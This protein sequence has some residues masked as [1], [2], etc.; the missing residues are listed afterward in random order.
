MAARTRGTWNK[1]TWAVGIAAAAVLALTGYAM[2]SGDE[3]PDDEQG[4]GGSNPS[5]ASSASPSATYQAPEDWTEPERWAALPRGK[6]TDS[7]GSEVGYPH[8]TEGAAAMLA[9]ANTTSVDTDTSTVDEQL[10]IYHSYVSQR[11]QSSE[12]AEQIELQA[13]Q[14]D[15]SLHKQMSVSASQPLPSG[16]YIRSS[17]VGYKVVK[18]SASEVSVWLLSRVVQKNGETAKEKSSYTRVL[19]GAAWEGGDW[20]LSGAVTQRGMEAAQQ[21]SQPPMAAPG[22]AAFNRS[23]WTAIREAS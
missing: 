23:G 8:T 6:E 7:R 16:A 3:G 12:N 21:E 2:F 20:K 4:K 19:N 22:D 17:V 11:D 13:L 18:E 5:A 9:A 14:T 1:G 10:R 15:K